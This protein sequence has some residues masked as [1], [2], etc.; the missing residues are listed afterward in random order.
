MIG[1]HVIDKMAEHCLQEHFLI[2]IEKR[3]YC[4]VAGELLLGLKCI[5]RF[6]DRENWGIWKQ[7]KWKTE[8]EN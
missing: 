7:W 8:M 2:K 1:S 5:N 6:L 4:F 3:V